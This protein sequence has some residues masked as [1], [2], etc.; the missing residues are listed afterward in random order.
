MTGAGRARLRRAVVSA[1]VPPWAR[2]R[3]GRATAVR[4]LASLEPVLIGRSW[5][6]LWLYTESTGPLLW[7]YAGRASREVGTLVTVRAVRG[8]TW[9]YYGSA[10]GR[11]R[12]WWFADCGDTLAAAERLEGHLKHRMFPGTFADV[13]PWTVGTRARAG[14]GA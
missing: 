7:V 8:G 9:S 11:Q 6:C 10:D 4:H 2:T 14:N 3:L 13:P 5:R 1:A 12:A